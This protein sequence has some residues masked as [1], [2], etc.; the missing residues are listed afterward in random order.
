VS[1]AHDPLSPE[2]DAFL[3]L[4]RRRPDPPDQIRDAV[5]SR[6]GTTLGWPDG[7]E[8]GGSDTS[9]GP[10]AGGQIGS[11]DLAAHGTTRLVTGALAKTLAT[12]VV[13]GVLGA[14]IHEAYDRVSDRKGEPAT[15][16]AVA[17]ASAAPTPALPVP[18]AAEPARPA[19]PVPEPAAA[20]A[21][22]A[23]SAVEAAP[24]AR[25]ESRAHDRSL[26]AERGL[27][28]QARTALARDQSEAALAVLERHARDFPD[29]ELEEERE[30]LQVPALVRLERF[31]QARKVGARF[32]RRFPRSIFGPVVDGALGSI[33]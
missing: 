11:G 3:D 23:K 12:L 4:E 28:E 14:G 19:V 16:A 26:A 13:G 17:P 24:A 5:L 8:P 33:P 32:H 20:S 22:H 21:V 1:D 2:V 15:V 10:S 29:G 27:I 18:V 25:V 31:E 7:S 6:I 9:D 30:S